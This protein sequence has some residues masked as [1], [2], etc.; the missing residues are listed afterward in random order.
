MVEVKNKAYVFDE[1]GGQVSDF[2][3]L[4]ANANADLRLYVRP[5][6]EIA[7]SVTAL[8][9]IAIGPIPQRPLVITVPAP[10]FDQRA[11]A[12]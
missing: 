9:N 3:D 10:S 11:P 6:S 1:R 8:P 5:G 2:S 7:S 4:A 12:K